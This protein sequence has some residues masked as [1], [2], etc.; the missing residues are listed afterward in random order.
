MNLRTTGIL[1]LI[2]AG[3]FYTLERVIAYLSTYIVTIGKTGISVDLTV[4][5]P[6]FFDNLFVPIFAFLGSVLFIVDLIIKNK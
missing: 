3:F 2:M 5:Y 1:L 4:L 6:G